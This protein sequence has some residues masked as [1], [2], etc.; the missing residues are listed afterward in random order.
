MAGVVL[1]AVGV[2]D[3]LADH[4]AARIDLKWLTAF[5]AVTSLAQSTKVIPA[6][7]TTSDP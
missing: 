4:V 2:P 1:G 6:A 7:S 5:R 3:G